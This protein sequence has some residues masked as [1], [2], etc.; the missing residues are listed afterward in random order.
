MLILHT[1][2][3]NNLEAHA[4]ITL[5]YAKTTSTPLQANSSQHCSITTVMRA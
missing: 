3:Q 1:Q 4:M 5:M 2:A